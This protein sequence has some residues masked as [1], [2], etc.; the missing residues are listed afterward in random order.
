MECQDI[1]DLIK[2]TEQAHR[3]KDQLK[4]ATEG[5]KQRIIRTC[6]RIIEYFT[7]T[8][9]MDQGSVKPGD[10]IWCLMPVDKEELM[11]IPP[12]HRIRPYVIVSIDD[13]YAYGF[14]CSSSLN[15]RIQKKKQYYIDKQTYQNSKSSYVDTTRLWEMP[16]EYMEA[17]YY[18]LDNIYFEGI[19]T[20]RDTHMGTSSCT[21]QFGAG[22]VVWSNEQLYY[23]YGYKNEKYLTH[24]LLCEKVNNTH[25][26]LS[27]AV[28]K[29]VYY[30]DC[31]ETI[32]L[33]EKHKMKK[34]MQLS[35][36]N[37]QIFNEKKRCV[38][39]RPEESVY[40]REF[41]EHMEQKYPI[42]QCFHIP[43]N[44]YLFLYF[45]HREQKAYG[46]FFDDEHGGYSLRKQR[47]DDPK[48]SLKKDDELIDYVLNHM[49]V[50]R[51]DQLVIDY[52]KTLFQKQKEKDSPDN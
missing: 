4:K 40:L 15:K 37:I 30:L 27:F 46:V 35:K 14:A 19:I 5:M 17:Y 11:Q 34:R 25:K 36:K 43:G 33:L 10:V 50:S 29:K 12:G 38:L 3:K 48:F 8:Q 13:D 52:V 9:T 21:S 44:N 42:G 41:K 26:Y 16:Y 2:D 20:C 49:H 23:V 18:T 22:S 45:F 31:S 7:E 6:L 1:K 39:K 47:L 28:D 32:C 51:N 24:A